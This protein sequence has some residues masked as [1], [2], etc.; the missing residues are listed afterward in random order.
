MSVE[1][2]VISIYI[3]SQAWHKL[4]ISHIY[5][6]HHLYNSPN[7]YDYIGQLYTISNIKMLI[8]HIKAWVAKPKM[9]L[10]KR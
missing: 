10:F 5:N 6:P 2:H 4:G 7:L 1:Q 9:H 3:T 8:T